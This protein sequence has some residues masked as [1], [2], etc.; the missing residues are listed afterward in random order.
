MVI[1]NHGDNGEKEVAVS[2]GAVM[3]SFDSNGEGWQWLY[4]MIIVARI[5]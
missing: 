1:V 3:G 4:G 5:G 2:R